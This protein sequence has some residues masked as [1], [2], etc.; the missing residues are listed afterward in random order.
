MVSNI[1]IVRQPPNRLETVWLH[2]Q[3]K[4]QP[5]VVAI[6]RKKNQSQNFVN[7]PKAVIKKPQTTC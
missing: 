1:E 6:D 4:V 7:K 5:Q 2:S 3:E